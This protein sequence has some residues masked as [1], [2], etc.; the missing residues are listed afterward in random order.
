MGTNDEK[1]IRTWILVADSAEARLFLSY[2]GQQGWFELKTFKHPQSR[3]KGPELYDSPL[4]MEEGKLPKD[5]AAE[6]FAHELGNYLDLSLSQNQYERLIIVA[7]P[8]F[9]GLLRGELS[10]Q[11]QT[12]LVETLNKDLVALPKDE[13]E[14]R[15]SEH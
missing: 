15:V 9:L 5:L 3:A 8:Q 14:D 4:A 2:P 6:D 10:K 1:I 12:H 11:V 13:L 7:P